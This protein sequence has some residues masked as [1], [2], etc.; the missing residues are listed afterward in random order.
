MFYT[1]TDPGFFPNTDLDPDCTR[2]SKAITKIRVADP[3]HFWPDPDPANKN[4]KN[5]IRIP[6]PTG[7]YQKSIQ[8]SIFSHQSDFF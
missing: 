8:T 7:T 1:H 3:V 4:F 2:F 5:R 6:D